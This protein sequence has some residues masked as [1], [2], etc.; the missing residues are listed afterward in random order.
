MYPVRSFWMTRGIV[1]GTIGVDEVIVSLRVNT[2]FSFDFWIDEVD[3][4]PA[5][6]WN[7][8]VRASELFDG[9]WDDAQ[10]IDTW[11]FGG[12]SEEDLQTDAYTEVRSPR[13]D[14]LSQRFQ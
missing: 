13:G 14:V 12:G 3:S 7:G 6:V 5:H 4:I 10:A 2:L 11:I 8:L 9:T 1:R